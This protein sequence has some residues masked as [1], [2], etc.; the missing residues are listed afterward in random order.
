MH[1][2]WSGTGVYLFQSLPESINSNLKAYLFLKQKYNLMAEK[3][4]RKNKD[5]LSIVKNSRN[6]GKFDSLDDAVFIRDELVSCDWNLDLIDDVYHVGDEYWVVRAIDGKIHLLGKFSRKPSDKTINKLYKKRLRNPNNSKYGLNI[7]KVFDTFVIKKMIA[8]DDY[9][10]GYYDNLSDA[11]FVRNYLLDNSWNVDEFS[12]IQYDEDTD[13]YRVIEVIDDRVYV[14]DA[15][16]SEDEI[17]LDRCH[18]EFLSK[19]SKHKYGLA[20]HEYLSELTDKIPELEERFGVKATDDVWSFD[21]TQDPLNDIVFNLT[22]FQKSVY[23]AVDG[24]TF[25]DI[26]KSL[27]RFKTPNFDKKIQRNLD[28]LEGMDLIR[29]DDGVYKKL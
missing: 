19:I 15:F 1:K 24:S 28:E 7:S 10:F 4:I 23:D 29:N 13:T 18:E 17:D 14:L 5:S 21:N 16:K 3:Y 11:E 6:Y 12:Q 25:D 8:Y 22:P 2:F 20:N 27:V 26:K 9:I